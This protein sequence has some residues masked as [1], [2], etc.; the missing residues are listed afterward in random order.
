MDK[1]KRTGL[2]EKGHKVRKVSSK[3]TTRRASKAKTLKSNGVKPIQL[4]TCY[5]TV[6]ISEF[7]VP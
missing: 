5:S 7:T 2:E 1:K 6:E 3:N 4:K